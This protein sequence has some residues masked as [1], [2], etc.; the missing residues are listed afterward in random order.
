MCIFVHVLRC[1]AWAEARQES[2]AAVRIHLLAAMCSAQH[3]QKKAEED[4]RVMEETMVALQ[5]SLE[6][7]MAVQMSA[8][9]A[10]HQL[11]LKA[12]GFLAQIAAGI[13]NETVLERGGSV[14]W[15]D[16]ASLASREGSF[17]GVEAP[18]RGGSRRGSM[19]D[20]G[21]PGERGGSPRDRGSVRGSSRASTRNTSPRRSVKL[22]QLVSPTLL[23]PPR[24]SVPS[25]DAPSHQS[26]SQLLPKPEKKPG[27]ISPWEWIIGGAGLGGN[28]STLPRAGS[29]KV[30]RTSMNQPQNFA[31]QNSP[32]RDSL[33]A[34]CE[35]TGQ[36][37]R[38]SN[39]G[40]LGSRSS[41]LAQTISGR[42]PPLLLQETEQRGHWR[43][44]LDVQNDLEMLVDSTLEGMPAIELLVARLP[45]EMLVTA[46][47][48]A[49]QGLISAI[50]QREVNTVCA[51]ASQQGL[52]QNLHS[53][54]L[55]YE[56]RALEAQ[57][58]TTEAQAVIALYRQAL[59]ELH[60]EEDVV[61]RRVKQDCAGAE[62][63]CRL[64]A[65]LEL[66]HAIGTLSRAAV[67]ESWDSSVGLAARIAADEEE[68]L[69]LGANA[70]ADATKLS[71]RQ[72]NET[73]L[74]VGERGILRSVDRPVGASRLAQPSLSPLSSWIGD[75]GGNWAEEGDQR[76]RM[77]E[78]LLLGGGRSALTLSASD[79]SVVGSRKVSF[80]ATAAE[81]ASPRHSGE[82]G[83]ARTVQLTISLALDYEYA[84][85]E[86]SAQRLVF[87]ETTTAD[88]RCPCACASVS[89][90][91]SVRLSSLCTPRTQCGSQFTCPTR[92]RSHDSRASSSLCDN[93]QGLAS[94]NF[95]IQSV[96]RGST[97]RTT[98]LDLFVC[99]DPADHFRGLDA[100]RVARSLEIQSRDA[101]SV[102]RN[103]NITRHTRSVSLYFCPGLPH[104]PAVAGLRALHSLAHARY[105][106]AHC[107]SLFVDP[108]SFFL[109]LSRAP[110][111]SVHP[112]STCRGQ[113]RATRPCYRLAWQETA[114]T[115]ALRQRAP[116]WN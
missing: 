30:S 82:G 112:P 87:V 106:R 89:V 5:Y 26:L 68:A 111:L 55:H 11:S 59:A 32:K 90:R 64:A 116:R 4:R 76:R 37:V 84:G 10:A 72:S 58:A 28:S 41:Q 3:Q 105:L 66:E 80:D 42:P 81:R 83:Q 23:L 33:R 51:A 12:C 113:D 50:R 46:L 101:S 63:A 13:D 96:S 75:A 88:L 60:R 92:T 36:S 107:L 20:P 48:T 52:L 45:Q 65:A 85:S 44:A 14:R 54:R 104:E 99:S 8:L 95:Q 49:L 93:G 39:P 17:F 108:L 31:T 103:G 110:S 100:S 35:D 6:Q 91:L 102:L 47:E 77:L 71:Q 109:P 69:L 79:P 67:Q 115:R 61:R 34:A 97:P 2:L 24:A 57:S 15:E 1:I 9:T 86:D 29:D 98:I 94:R 78:S 25:S 27:P 19:G 38:N 114:S 73:L 16:D 22:G 18:S 56:E 7:E 43:H 53:V 40:T 70:V 74:A 21:S 62:E